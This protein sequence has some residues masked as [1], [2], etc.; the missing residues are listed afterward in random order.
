MTGIKQSLE[1]ISTYK[2]YKLH[3]SL[4]MGNNTRKYMRLFIHMVHERDVFKNKI[5][6]CKQVNVLHNCLKY[7]FYVH[8]TLKKISIFHYNILSWDAILKT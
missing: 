1:I 3:K 2:N 4:H 5:K 7:Y 8:S 6:H